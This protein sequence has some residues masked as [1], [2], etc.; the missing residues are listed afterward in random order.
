[1]IKNKGMNH[2]QLSKAHY[3]YPKSDLSYERPEP[4]QHTLHY[5]D[6]KP[7]PGS[8]VGNNPNNESIHNPRV[9][10]INHL[11]TGTNLGLK[12]SYTH[13]GFPATA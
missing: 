5:R 6:S 12:Q 11:P 7:V 1:M 9:L 8:V 13:K 4:G 2:M 3:Y 10:S